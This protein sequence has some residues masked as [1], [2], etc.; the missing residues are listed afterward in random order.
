[1]NLSKCWQYLREIRTFSTYTYQMGEMHMEFT[2]CDMKKIEEGSWRCLVGFAV[3]SLERTHLAP[4]GAGDANQSRAEGRGWN[5]LCHVCRGPWCGV[6]SPQIIPQK[7]HV[8]D[9]P[10]QS[11]SRFFR[12]FKEPRR[13]GSFTTY[14]YKSISAQTYGV[15]FGCILPVYANICIHIITSYI[16]NTC[17]PIELYI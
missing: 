13:V 8:I 3:A 10:C 6:W 14:H 16:N 12:W 11:L 15:T 2:T 9:G 7:C 17:M 4:Q 5:P 1:M